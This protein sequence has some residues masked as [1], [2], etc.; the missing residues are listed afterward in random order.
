M[1]GWSS[2]VSTGSR[3]T[4]SPTSSKSCSWTKKHG[5]QHPMYIWTPAWH[6]VILHRLRPPQINP[7]RVP[8][9]GCTLLAGGMMGLP[10]CHYSKLLGSPSQLTWWCELSTET[11]SC[12]VPLTISCLSAVLGWYGHTPRGN[13]PWI[14]FL[15]HSNRVPSVVIHLWRMLLPSIGSVCIPSLLSASATTW[16]CPGT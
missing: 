3:R 15:F 6:T 11:P 2:T 16:F 13:L 7:K 12:L 10:F 9:I 1:H 5:Y 4:A 14:A 8:W